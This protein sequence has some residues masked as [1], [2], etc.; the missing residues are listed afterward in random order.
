MVPYSGTLRADVLQLDPGHVRASLRDRRRVRNHLRSVHAIAMTN[1]GELS[2]G[3]ALLGA[4]PPTARGILTG[5]ETDFL[6][7]AR[8]VLVAEARCTVPE[9][10]ATMEHV[11]EA[12]IVDTGGDVVAVVRARW[13][14]GPVVAPESGRARAGGAV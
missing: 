2:T 14:L 1:L 4:L 10:H 11:V 8:G 13:R 5:I 3:L 6:K 7:K 9:V 12:R